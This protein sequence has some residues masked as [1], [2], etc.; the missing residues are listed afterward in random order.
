MSHVIG[1]VK[2]PGETANQYIFITSDTKNVKVGEFVYYQ[3]PEQNLNIIGKIAALQLLDHLPDRIFADTAIDPSTI[4]AL[5]GFKEPNPEIYGVTVEVIG[6]FHD[7][8]GFINPRRPPDPGAKVFLASAEMLRSVLNKRDVHM[9]GGAHLGSL[10]LRVHEDVPVVLDVKEMVSTHLAI[11]AGTGSG[12]SYTAGVLIEELLLPKN[13]AAVLILDP[14][15]EYDTLA[16][17]QTN[18]DFWGEDGYRPK[19]QVLS[20]EE[21]KI[22]VSSLNFFDILTLLPEMSE[23]QKSFL[24][25]AYHRTT[26]FSQHRWTIQDL[27]DA[28]NEADSQQDGSQGTSAAALEWKLEQIERSPYFSNIEHL[29][30]RD[31][32]EPGQVTILQMNE[33]SQEEQQVITAAILRQ[34]NHA[35]MNT[36]KGRISETDENYLP[37]PVFILIEEAHRFAPAHEPS[38]CKQVLRTILSEGRKFGLGVGLITQR[39]GKLDSD[40]L[41]QCMSQFLMRIVN[42]TDQENLRHSVE[43]AGRDLLK[44]LPALSKGQVIVSGVCVNT[45]VLCKVRKRLTQHGGTTIEI[46]ENWQKYFQIQQ[47]RERLVKAAPLRPRLQPQVSL[48]GLSID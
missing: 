16:E 19:V 36:H 48:D 42:P 9:K 31:L 23:R 22:R 43:A 14:H 15:G 41:S 13:R 29:A 44:E 3:L 24:E 40:I 37:Y 39:P 2:G 1:T 10:L 6:Y 32:F 45:P 30:P 35:R 26:Q 8:M 5:V 18:T 47:Q 7:A 27:I 28:V 17:M 4:V 20:P 11:L 46:V 33:I 34:A 38:R 12:K 25:K 21:I